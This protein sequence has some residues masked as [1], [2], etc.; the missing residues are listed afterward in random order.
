MARSTGIVQHVSLK[1]AVRNKRSG[2][3]G[4][5]P[6]TPSKRRERLAGIRKEAR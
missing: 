6:E 3:K 1:H 4:R 5:S 2:G